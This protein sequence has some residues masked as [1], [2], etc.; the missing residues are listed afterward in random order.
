MFNQKKSK[1]LISSPQSFEHR[2]HTGY[3]HSKGS[4]VGLPAQWTNIIESSSKNASHRY[5]TTDDGL[6][7][8][9]LSFHKHFNLLERL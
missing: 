9:R 7:V 1:I 5:D 2:L 6:K 4:Y 8:S 3:D